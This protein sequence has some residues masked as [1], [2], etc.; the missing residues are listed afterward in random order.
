MANDMYPK[1]TVNLA[2]GSEHKAQIENPDMCRLE[3]VGG[4]NGFSLEDQ[5]I[6]SMTYLAWANLK[7]NG[8]YTDS[9]DQFREHDCIG[10]D[11]DEDDEADDGTIEDPKG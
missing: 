4:R 8:L 3:L 10:F 11:I 2:D 1:L 5:R 7:R 6:V 9:W